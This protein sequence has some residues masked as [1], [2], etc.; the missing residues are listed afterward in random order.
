MGRRVSNEAHPFGGSTPAVRTNRGASPFTRRQ[1]VGLAVGGVATA[2]GLILFGRHG[3][4]AQAGTIPVTLY[5]T[6]TCQC[7]HKWRTHLESNGFRVTTTYLTDLDHKKDS[8]GVPAE[9][10]SCHTAEIEGYL[11]EG[12]VPAD[13]ITRFLAERPAARGLAAPGMPGG[14]PGMEDMPKVPF[15]VIAFAANGTTRVYARA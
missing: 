3:L 12:H 13:I 6:S 4:A 2:A 10:R 5:A 1:W 9:L 7:C 14:S 8:L 11:V 15:D